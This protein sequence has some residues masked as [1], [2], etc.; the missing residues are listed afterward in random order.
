MVKWLGGV[1]AGAGWVFLF[2]WVSRR[3][4]RQADTF[5]VQYLAQH[6]QR[7]TPRANCDSSVIDLWPIRVMTGALQQ[8]ADL[9][10]IPI[11][12]RSWRHGS[13]A[14]RQAYLRRLVGT[15]I[16]RQPID[17][18]IVMIK[19]VSAIT[20]MTLALGEWFVKLIGLMPVGPNDQSDAYNPLPTLFR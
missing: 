8:V 6:G 4:E 14:W 15:P 5:A 19:V 9:N 18:Q 13:I 1:A 12:R 16:D 17:R 11:R 3:F 10:N 7:T 20:I 2:G